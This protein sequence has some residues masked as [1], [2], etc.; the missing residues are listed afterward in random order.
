MIITMTI[1]FIL[2]FKKLDL[3]ARRNC[4]VNISM[5]VRQKRSRKAK[6]WILH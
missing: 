5:W 3:N 1:E 2:H 6:A 4:F